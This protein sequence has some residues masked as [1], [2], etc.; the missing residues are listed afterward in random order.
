MGVIVILF[1][2]LANASSWKIKT[3]LGLH[4][5]LGHLYGAEIS[6]GKQITWFFGAVPWVEPLV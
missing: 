2:T 4:A 6:A 1:I 3:F 5:V